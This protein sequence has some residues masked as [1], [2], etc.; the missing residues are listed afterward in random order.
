MR[1]IRN[2]KAT[3]S[4]MCDFMFDRN[5]GL[6]LVCTKNVA[7]EHR[8]THTQ[9]RH[10]SCSLWLLTLVPCRLACQPGLVPWVGPWSFPACYV[11]GWNSRRP[12][13]GWKDDPPFSDGPAV[14]QVPTLHGEQSQ[15]SYDGHG[16]CRWG[17]QPFLMHLGLEVVTS[18]LTTA[19][20]KTCWRQWAQF[21]N[22]NHDD[23]WIP[24]TSRHILPYFL[25]ILKALVFFSDAPGDL[26][27]VKNFAQGRSPS[28]CSKKPRSITTAPRK[29]V[30]WIPLGFLVEKMHNVSL[31]GCWKGK[32]PKIP[33]GQPS[34][35]LFKVSVSG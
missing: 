5:F 6:L 35:W 32:S 30:L 13:T 29:A 3:I 25:I 15:H 33:H 12:A 16:D 10:K 9:H 28:Y 22:L 17:D 4:T 20:G 34:T 11:P 8:K 1:C 24:V 18:Q 26:Q 21:A 31:P 7:A 2:L 23:T 19:I 14:Q 27:G